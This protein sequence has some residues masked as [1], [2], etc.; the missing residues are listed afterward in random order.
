MNEFRLGLPVTGVASFLRA[1]VCA[2]LTN[3]DADIGFLGV[4]YDEGSGWITGQRFAPRKI[5][6][7][8]VRFAGHALQSPGGFYDIDEGKKFLTHERNAGRFVDCGD[9][10][11]VV[12]NVRKTFDNITK[13][14][15][16]ILKAGLFPVTVGGDHSITF[17]ILRAYKEKFHIV[18]FDA[19]I[20]YRP[21][22]HGIYGNSGQPLK[23]ASELPN[24]GHIVQIGI[25]SLR[26]V[27]GQ[28][29]D[30]LARGNEVITV[31]QLRRRGPESIIKRL[32]KNEPV[33]VTVDIDVLDPPFIPGCSSAE[34]NGITYDELRQAMFVVARN[35]EVI[36]FDVTEVNPMI[37]LPAQNTSFLAAQL[38]VEFL[39]RVVEHPAYRKRHPIKGRLP[40]KQKKKGRSR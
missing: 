8:S 22:E 24:C 1:P 26:T 40:A 29:K 7:M 32:P 36:G 17:P 16:R 14:V 37:D 38:I 27:E 21:L 25:R 6:E 18:H 31:S 28:I 20:D 30:S 2:D 9:S 3:V 12:T 5:R 13:D 39:G 4:P 34:L 19:H 33:Y 35:R 11:I 23:L 10:D 15:R